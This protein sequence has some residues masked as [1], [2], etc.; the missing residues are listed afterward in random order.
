VT[1]RHLFCFG[2][3]YTARALGRR[4]AAEGWSVRGTIRSDKPGAAPPDFGSA[5]IPF[6]RRH[7]LPA[8]TLRGVSH[9]LV[10]IPPDADGDPVLDRQADEI[11]TLPGLAWLGYLSTTAV[12]GDRGGGWVD[13]TAVPSPSGERGR[14][15]VTAE[16]GWR[17]LRRRSGAPLHVF[18]LAAIY[19]PGRSP[20]AALRAGT[21]KRIDAPGQLFSRIHIDDLARAIAASMARPRPGA[22]YNLCDDEP[23]AQ[24]AVVGY[25]AELLGVPPPP[26]VPLA[27][28]GLSPAEASFY[29][30]NKR[31]D[32]A[33]V[34][35][36]LGIAW[37]YPN[38]RV[39]L[40]AILAA[41]SSRLA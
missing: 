5:T 22:V 31:V 3:G 27:A 40:T 38:Y 1:G 6:E 28:A 33:L 24:A 11:A 19:G 12:Y 16:A 2:F 35:R 30:D 21:A 14:R 34:K 37:R 7:P 36:E 9:I 39:G 25:A 10:S 17:E 20:F 15:R 29:T 18:R 4:L 41:E 32:N 13:E 23:A 8:G 26:P